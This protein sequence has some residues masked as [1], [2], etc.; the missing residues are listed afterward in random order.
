MLAP[1]A[2]LLAALAAPAPASARPQALGSD[3][4]EPALRAELAAAPDGLVLAI[5]LLEPLDAR[6]RADPALRRAVVA[7]RQGRVLERIV[8][9]GARVEPR[10]VYRNVAAFTARVDAAALERLARDPGVVAVGADAAG[11]GVLDESVPFVRADFVH[12]LGVTGAGMTVAVLDSGVD[13]DH[14]DLAGDVAPLGATFLFQGAFVAHGAED[15]HG[16]G[17]SVAGIVTAPNGVAPDA[18]ILP[19]KV[20]TAFNTGFLSDWAAGVDH[21]VSVAPQL[22]GVCAINM[23]LASFALYDACPCDAA[24]A[25]NQLLGAALASARAAGIVTFAASG[26]DGACDSMASPACLSGAVAV[27]AVYDADLGQEP[28][29]GTYG[30]GCADLASAPDQV[31][32]FSN[33]SPCNALAAP[34]RL[35]ATSTLGGG[36][37]TLFTGTSAATPHCAG[38]AALLAQLGVGAPDTIVAALRA[39]GRPAFDPCL[40]SP[41]PVTVDAIAA[42]ASLWPDRYCPLDARRAQQAIGASEP[43]LVVPLRWAALQDAPSIAAPGVACASDFELVLRARHAR[44]ADSV[45]APQARIVPRSAA[46]LDAPAFARLAD[47]DAAVG[48][49]GDVRVDAYLAPGGGV[50]TASELAR[51]MRDAERAYHDPGTSGGQPAG[52]VALHARRLTGAS[53]AP[54]APYALH[55]RSLA[56]PW[57]AVADPGELCAEQPIGCDVERAL[58]QALGLAFGLAPH[59]GDAPDDVARLMSASAHGGETLASDEIAAARATLAADPF[60]AR[61]AGTPPSLAARVDWLSDAT[62]DA[63]APWEDVAK[64]VVVDRGPSGGG[65]V[66]CAGTSGPLPR[67][68]RASWLFLLDVDADAN[69]GASPASLAPG[70]TLVGVDVVLECRVDDPLSATSRVWTAA[71]GG[72]FAPAAVGAGEH[73]GRARSR[74]CVPGRAPGAAAPTVFANT[75]AELDV[76]LTAAGAA[77]LGLPASGP[78]FPNGLRMQVALVRRGATP[79]TRDLAP[80]VAGVA[81]LASIAYPSIALPASVTPGQTV[82]ASVAGM[83]PS[84]PLRLR[85]GDREPDLGG[86]ATDASGAASFA[87]VVPADV[88]LGP[89]LV[90][91]GLDDSANPQIALEATTLVTVASGFAPFDADGDGVVGP[92]DLCAL[93]ACLTGPMPGLASPACLDAFDADGDADVDADDV[94]GGFLPAYR[95]PQVDCDANGTL[96]VLDVLFGAGVDD[97]CD[98]LLD[99][100]VSTYGRGCPGAGG[101]IPTLDVLGCAYAGGAVELAVAQALPSSPGWIALGTLPQLGQPGS[102]DVLVAPP[103]RVLPFVTGATGAASLRL[104]LDAIAPGTTLFLQAFVL[105]V[106]APTPTGTASSKGVELRVE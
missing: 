14:P 66:V 20:T 82:A 75:F 63:G 32:C 28:D 38:V 45:W 85:L 21:V 80:D 60:V 67:P 93:R 73:V 25:S 49:P 84:T 9:A 15:D 61:A 97:D 64:V 57:I 53:G 46:T 99:T 3:R 47:P 78:R 27:A 62:G 56:R 50:D 71:P 35:V 76:E 10:H 5:V 39:T 58:A 65:L 51:L 104:A 52:L 1:L 100:S 19:V 11:G 40:T 98:G 2:L 74:D 30:S 17:T 16:H 7:E 106:A 42:A 79:P 26:N 70:A 101:A 37:P 94:L 34:G 44:A 29:S 105:D 77:A 88:E 18:R 69:T 43:L 68:T 55:P 4:V 91:C 87:F 81:D 31:V 90:A 83:R 12:Q 102:C 24:S 54:V 92:R 103:A 59:P 8:A 13:T 22:G 86:A 33:R 96:D 72:G 95:G 36:E 6:E 23:S 48:L 41:P 89:T